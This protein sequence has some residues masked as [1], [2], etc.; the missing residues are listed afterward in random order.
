MK[1]STTEVKLDEV[2]S[3]N[4]GITVNKSE[5]DPRGLQ[6]KYFDRHPEKVKANQTY[7]K[8]YYSKPKTRLQT[9][10]MATS[11]N[12]IDPYRNYN[13]QNTSNDSFP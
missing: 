5:F 10:E 9:N 12:A 13:S 2:I 4:S 1:L 11:F 3:Q 7:D 8:K 6:S